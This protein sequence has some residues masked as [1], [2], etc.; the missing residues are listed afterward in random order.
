MFYH[1]VDRKRNG[2]GLTLKD[3]YDTNVIQE[4]RVSDSIMSMKLE[5]VVVT[6]VVMMNAR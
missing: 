5:T 1:G 2:V 3:E 6:M 4:K